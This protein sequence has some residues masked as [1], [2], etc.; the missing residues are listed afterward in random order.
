MSCKNLLL[1]VFTLLCGL[2]LCCAR[3]GLYDQQNTV[4][5]MECHFQDWV[6]KYT[7]VSNLVFYS[8]LDHWLWGRQADMTGM[9]L[10]RSPHG[11]WILGINQLREIR[12]RF[13][14]LRQRPTI[15]KYYNICLWKIGLREQ[16]KKER[17]KSWY[18]FS[19]LKKVLTVIPW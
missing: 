13:P 18:R 6:I 17:E 12:S 15:C 3:V 11:L 9:A 7:M 8:H 1:L 16:K 2:F 14:N 5:V 10:W 19:Y 4:Q